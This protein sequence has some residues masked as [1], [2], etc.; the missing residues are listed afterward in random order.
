MEIFENY[1]DGLKNAQLFRIYREIFKSKEESGRFNNI[2]NKI[3]DE[4]LKILDETNLE[5]MPRYESLSDFAKKTFLVKIQKTKLFIEKRENKYK[6]NDWLKQ[7]II[8][9]FYADEIFKWIRYS[10]DSNDFN[11]DG[12]FYKLLVHFHD[13]NKPKD[14]KLYY[15]TFLYIVDSLNFLEI[16]D[17]KIGFLDREGNEGMESRMVFRDYGKNLFTEIKEDT[18]F[19]SILDQDLIIKTERIANNGKGN[20]FFT[21]IVKYTDSVEIKRQK[22]FIKKVNKIYQKTNLTVK[23]DDAIHKKISFIDDL[24]VYRKNNSISL[25]ELDCEIIDNLEIKKQRRKNT[26][27]R[28]YDKFTSIKDNSISIIDKREKEG[29]GDNRDNLSLLIQN[30]EL[31]NNFNGIYPREEDAGKKGNDLLKINKMCFE[32][33]KKSMF[34][35]YSRN[36]W[37]MHGRWYGGL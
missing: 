19:E 33:N 11:K 15:Y 26:D 32:I 9:L 13:G 12:Y 35:V 27:L 22:E 31:C 36:S 6:F 34:R 4:I 30:Y 1:D 5:M 8:N 24:Y 3:R 17:H 23:V 16:I 18:I 7:I 29:Y 37:S 20:K 2:C 14:V 25:K 10:R 21:K 28:Y